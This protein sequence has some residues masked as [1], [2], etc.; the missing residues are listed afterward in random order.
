MEAAVLMP[1]KRFSAA[2]GRL[3]GLLD[4]DR[5]AE[6]ARWLANRVAAAADLPLFVA[7]DDDEVVGWADGAGAEVLWSPGL[8]LNG[9][10]DAGRATMT[11]KGFDHVVIAHSDLPLASSLA[12]LATPGTI[13]LV[14]DRRRDGTNVLSLPHDA[15]VA[16]SYGGGSFSRHLDQAMRSGCR[17]EVRADARLAIDVDN[18]DDLRHPAVE[19]LLPTWLRT[20][21]A[22]PN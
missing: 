11:D 22:S 16:A 2:K 1:V 3:S 15:P 17:V 14:P 4:G 9:A 19:P 18:P 10:V 8:G 13:C 6:L 20:I 12:S 5:R 7:C 21:L